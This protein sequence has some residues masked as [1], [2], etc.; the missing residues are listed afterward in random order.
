MSIFRSLLSSMLLA[1]AAFP[2]LAQAATWPQTY[3]S[4]SGSI[5]VYQ[6]QVDGF[7]QNVLTSHA[8]VS[9]TPAGSTSPVFGAMWFSATVQTD[10]DARTVQ[11]QT[12]TV[13][14]SRFPGSASV[15]VD[16]LSSAISQSVPGTDLSL[17]SIL[18]SLSTTQKQQAAS[19]N[20]NNTPPNLI[21]SDVPAVLVTLDG[22]PQLAP[23]SGTGL[24]RVVNTPFFIVLDVAAKTYYLEGPGTWLSASDINGPWQGAANVP[25]TV[26]QLASTQ[27]SATQAGDQQAMTA[28]SL[29]RIIV[30]TQ[31]SELIQTDGP[32]QFSTISGT[33]LLYVTN[34]SSDVFMDIN[35]QAL[36]VLISGRWYTAT[37]KNGPWSYVQ[38][39]QLP[40]DFAQIPQGSPKADVLAFVPSTQAA[41]NA[42]LD[43]SVPQTAT[44]KAD[45]PA[46][47]V[48]YDGAPK[49]QPVSGTAMQYAVNTSS[50][51]VQ[52]GQ[53]YY[54]CSDGIWFVGGSPTGPWTVCT[55][56]PEVVYTIPP[57][58]PI[59][60]V[61]YCYVY[62][63]GPGVVYCG[64]LPGYL[65][66][67]VYGGTMVFGTGWAYPAW[68]NGSVFIPRP[69][70]WGFGASFSVSTGGWGFSIGS[71]WGGAAFSA[72]FVAG[73]WWGPAG[74]RS[75]SW[76]GGSNNNWRSNNTVNVT[77]NFNTN[78]YNRNVNRLAAN[79]TI[80]SNN[81]INNAHDNQIASNAQNRIN[82]ARSDDNNNSPS[83][84]H[85]DRDGRNI[86]AGNDGKVYKQSLDGWQQRS[87]DDWHSVRG[88][89]D[90]SSFHQNVEPQLNRDASARNT[91]FNRPDYGGFERG[92][93]MPRGGGGGFRR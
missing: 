6:P 69:V 7:S 34:T 4:P 87:G 16:Q 59:Y 93:G 37:S 52:V 60:N 51:I 19:A 91:Q 32:A 72:G 27:K 80:N 20:F 45:A 31:P 58:C 74:W 71:G 63:T 88:S 90:E 65:G 70:T 56:V 55:T 76:N 42:V 50:S 49:F 29:P 5:T 36:Y 62:G 3:Q 12:L 44:V 64:Y 23:V 77:N 92:G 89:S 10:R 13:T 1:A 17:D 81:R 21:Y 2:L 46:P 75:N 57:Q 11:I 40:P 43:A 9:Y 73:G 33:S 53:Q 24:M 84:R 86:Y 68:I 30:T 28:G 14:N 8:A 38:P 85:Q 83:D 25:T 41:Q 18:A 67:Y 22:A 78:V 35:S 26:T 79:N 15:P 48:K 82:E 66:S 61:T 47:D 39:S 54:L